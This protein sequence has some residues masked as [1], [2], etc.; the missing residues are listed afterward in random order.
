MLG[1]PRMRL[2]WYG[3]VPFLTEMYQVNGNA[4][5]FTLRIPGTDM[6]VEVFAAREGLVVDLG[7]S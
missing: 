5:N 1:D 7:S 4:R 3:V 2:G 6:G